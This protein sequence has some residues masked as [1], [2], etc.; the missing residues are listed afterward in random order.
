MY[1]HIKRAGASGEFAIE[2][3]LEIAEERLRDGYTALKYSI[4]PP[5]KAIENPENT[6]KHI[7]RFAKV[8][9]KR[10]CASGKVK[11]LSDERVYP[12]ASM[13]FLRTE[14]HLVGDVEVFLVCLDTMEA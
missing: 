6:Q 12:D 8:R 7:E 4:I 13:F 1:T 9:K 11:I 5:I 14:R 3:M 10:K 2:E